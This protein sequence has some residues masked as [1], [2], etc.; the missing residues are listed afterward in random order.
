MT[1]TTIDFSRV[2]TSKLPLFIAVVVFLAFLLLI[3][4]FRSLLTPL[5][6]SALNLPPSAQRWE[7]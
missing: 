3:A 1:A 4:V 7:P 6:A 2:L 5:V